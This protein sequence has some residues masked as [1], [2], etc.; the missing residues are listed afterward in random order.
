MTLNFI[1]QTSA[2]SVCQFLASEVYQPVTSIIEQIGKTS[3]PRISKKKAPK[4]TAVAKKSTA[5]VK[6]TTIQSPPSPV[7][8]SLMEM[9]FS[10]R[11]ID[12]AIKTTGSSTNIERLVGWLLEHPDVEVAESECEEEEDDVTPTGND[13]PSDA[14][15]VILA[16]SDTESSTTSSDEEDSDGGRT[17]SDRVYKTR[18]QFATVDDYATYVKDHLHVGMTIQCCESYEEVKAGDIGKV[19]KVR[20]SYLINISRS[21][22][23]Q[24]QLD[25][26]GLHDL[27]VQALWENKGGSYWLRYSHCQILS[28]QELSTGQS[29]AVQFKM[30]DKVRVKSSVV[31]PK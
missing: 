23:G 28:E 5:K 7:V 10:R 29:D 30:G 1:F 26:D 15:A 19:T 4:T 11:I 14:K 21:Q 20:F 8:Q 9:G 31:T 18:D 13:L 16:K 25:S 17:E 3:T 27:N 22:N 24:L 6:K 12:H 2:V